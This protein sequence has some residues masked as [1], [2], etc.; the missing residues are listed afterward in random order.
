MFANMHTRLGLIAT[1]DSEREQE[2]GVR[3]PSTLW[4][5]LKSGLQIGPCEL[6]DGENSHDDETIDVTMLGH[7]ICAG[8]AYGWTLQSSEIA[9]LQQRFPSDDEI[10]AAKGRVG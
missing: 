3:C 10:A 8:N 9:A 7:G 4:L 1:E 5:H 2:Y 6:T